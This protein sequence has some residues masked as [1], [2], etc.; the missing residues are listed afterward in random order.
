MTTSFQPVLRL[1]AAGLGARFQDREGRRVVDV[2]RRLRESAGGVD[3]AAPFGRLEEA[4]SDLLRVDARLRADEALHQL[5]LGHLE[6]EDQRG[7]AQLDGGVRGD[8]EREG[9]LARGRA[10]RDDHEVR[11]LQP[12]GALVELP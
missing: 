8:I 10:P 2:Q 12:R 1:D 6:A 11:A 5:L 3:D 4:R 7:S 9:R